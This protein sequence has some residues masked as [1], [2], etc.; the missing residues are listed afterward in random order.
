M[1]NADNERKRAAKRARLRNEHKKDIADR[2]LWNIPLND[3]KSGRVNKKQLK[4]SGLKIV[5]VGSMNIVSKI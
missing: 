4:I 1:K 2:R 5:K 3:G